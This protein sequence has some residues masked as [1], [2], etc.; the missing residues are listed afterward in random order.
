MVDDFSVDSFKLDLITPSKSQ[1]INIV[2]YDH[3]T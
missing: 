2:S 1:D 3:N